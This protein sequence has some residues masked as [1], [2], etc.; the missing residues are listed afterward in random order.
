MFKTLQFQDCTTLQPQSINI[1]P[2]TS[3]QTLITVIY[4]R[5]K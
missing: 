4:C 3:K 2:L 1:F 5:R